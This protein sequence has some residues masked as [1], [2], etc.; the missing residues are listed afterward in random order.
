MLAE[1]MK[2]IKPSKI[3]EF[4]A[5]AKKMKNEGIKVYD[6]TLG[7]PDFN[8]PDHIKKAAIKAINDNKSKYT[9]VSG[10]MELKTIISEK[11]KTENQLQYN[12]DQITVGNGAKQIIFNALMATLNKDDEVI[13]IS[14]FW[15]SYYDNILF[16]SGKAIIVETSIENNFK[17]NKEDLK[18]AITSKTKWIILNSPSNPTGV[19]YSKEELIEISTLLDEFPNLMIMSDEIYEYLVYEDNKH[20]SIA[21]LV[22]EENKNRIL[23]INGCSKAFAMTGWRIGYAGGN[24]DLI[25]AMNAIQSQVTSNPCSISQEAAIT[26]LKEEKQF[27]IEFISKYKERRD[28]L[29][30]KLNKIKGLKY[31]KSQ[32]AFY[33]FVD[34]SKLINKK[35]KET[36]INNSL[37]FCNIALDKFRIALIAGSFFGAEGFIRISFASSI[38]EVKKLCEI[39]EDFCNQIN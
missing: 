31:R 10:T 7:E 23:T 15:S 27:L 12:T 24:K 16:C 8:V 4:A 2:D 1:R 17:T 14:P 21:S 37:D 11:F 19:V 32:G 28:H 18:K 20:Y 13:I 5:K 3:F 26:A 25:N 30:E 38:E 22:K 33:A 34:I 6:F 9:I 39:L 36:S 29:F 35:Y